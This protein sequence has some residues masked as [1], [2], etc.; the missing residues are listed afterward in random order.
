MGSGTLQGE[1]GKLSSRV[2]LVRA[3]APWLI[4]LVC[5]LVSEME[6]LYVGDV[7]S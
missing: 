3:L 5:A 6:E 4:T 1:C 2:T 7:T